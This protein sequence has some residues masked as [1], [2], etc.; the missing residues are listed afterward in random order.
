MS[1]T[2]WPRCPQA[3]AFF[4]QQ[5]RRFAAGN[6][7]VTEM[8][9]RFLQVAGVELRFL[10]DH[11]ALPETPELREQLDACGLQE[12]TTA[13]GDPVWRHPQARFPRVRL[14]RSGALPRLALRTEDVSLFLTANRL[15]M[16]ARHGDPDSGY[17]EAICTLPSGELA[18][19]A[20]RGCDGFRPRGLSAAEAK[21]LARAR[22]AFAAR[23]R[24][25]E[26]AEVLTRTQALVEAVV[27]EIGRDRATDEF[28]AAERAFYLRR[29]RAARS[30]YERQQ[31]LGLGW[32]NHD[33]HTYRS[34][35]AA[36]RA[37]TGLWHTF[38]FAD[39]ERFYAGAE[40]GWGAQILEH[41]VS[42]VV[43]FA[44]VDMAPEERDVDF[45]TVDLPPRA[46]LG[47]IGLWCA[48][49]GSSIAGAGM[50]HLEAEFDWERAK[51]LLE[52][53]GFGVMTPFTDLP[54]L[55]QAFTEAEVWPVAPERVEA[56]RE[57]DLLTGEQA[58]G[59]LARGAA[60]SHLEILQRWEGFKGFNK[61]GVSA[62][63]RET[64]ARKL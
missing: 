28:F 33:H 26:E 61:T 21:K 16:T 22:A 8:A 48:L 15:A 46:T 52:A 3:A 44:D 25:G 5:F 45:A 43:L 50:H 27:G 59:F 13:E 11:W 41:S 47:T 1:D 58:T 54:F 37:L 38:G 34:S 10:I 55:K 7:P 6:P 19:V 31:G 29:N 30:Q 40:A 23:G 18:V 9:A 4:D 64:D 42:P 49:H 60:G 53:A 51:A 24:E 35:R 62:I 17:E 2:I 39:R 56:L 63:L 36:F 12:T 57:R 20:R 32:A 14:E